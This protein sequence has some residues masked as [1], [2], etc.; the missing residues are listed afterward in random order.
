MR[1]FRAPLAREIT[2]VF[3]NL[4]VS[5]GNCWKNYW[6]SLVVAMM[7]IEKFRISRFHK[8]III[9][10][11]TLFEHETAF[12][13]HK[14]IVIDLFLDCLLTQPLNENST[15][16]IFIIINEEFATQTLEYKSTFL[17]YTKCYPLVNNLNI[18][19]Y[20]LLTL[21]IAETCKVGPVWIQSEYP[22]NTFSL[23]GNAHTFKQFRAKIWKYFRQHKK[24]FLKCYVLI[25]IFNF[26]LNCVQE[27]NNISMVL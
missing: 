16:S 26:V 20:S 4:T 8:N 13:L 14:S 25:R 7:V 10:W 23:K 3:P 15:T 9:M 21:L 19:R 22:S 12:H 6:H 1:R 2:N 5:S 24:S 18:S 27:F 11:F 17:Q